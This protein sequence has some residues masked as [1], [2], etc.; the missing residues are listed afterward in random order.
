MPQHSQGV[1]VADQL[2]Q[3]DVLSQVA[4]V[5]RGDEQH[6]TRGRRQAGGEGEGVLSAESWRRRS[7]VR[8]RI[9]LP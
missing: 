7:H 1:R 6:L 5:E 4:A 9:S 2:G 8:T 3:G